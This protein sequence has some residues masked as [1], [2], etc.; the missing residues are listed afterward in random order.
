MALPSWREVAVPHEDIRRGGFDESTFAA[1]LAD[2]LADR[3]P[4]EYRDPQTF[5]RKTYP[6]EGMVKLLAAVLRR[7]AGER[8]GEPVIQIQTPFGGGKTHSLVALYH[9]FRAEKEAQEAELVRRASRQF[10]T[11]RWPSSSARRSTP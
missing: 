7:L 10:Q 2:V 3:G 8:G 5:F 9:L 1:D 11:P 6:T 4:L